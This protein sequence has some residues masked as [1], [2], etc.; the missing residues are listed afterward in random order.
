MICAQM[1]FDQMFVVEGAY[2][3]C[4]FNATPGTLTCATYPAA[5]SAA[6]A[7]TLLQTR[8][9]TDKGRPRCYLL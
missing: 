5:V 6:P 8:P 7:L 4:E 1:M 3:H 2:R 9:A